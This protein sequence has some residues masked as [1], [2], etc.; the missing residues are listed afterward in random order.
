M[1]FS[2]H[3]VFGANI[4]E[5]KLPTFGDT[6]QIPGADFSQIKLMVFGLLIEPHHRRPGNSGG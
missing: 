3:L 4:T 6:V 2:Y 5:P 1:S